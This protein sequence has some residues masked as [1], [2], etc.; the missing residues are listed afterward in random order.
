MI[1]RQNVGKH[2]H[3]DFPGYPNSR[4]SVQVNFF[5]LK[6]EL[7]HK[8]HYYFTA[9]IQYNFGTTHTV[10]IKIVINVITDL[11]MDIVY[12][13]CDIPYTYGHF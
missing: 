5:L 1:I 3:V 12:P 9:T 6:L 7:V 13:R 10:H 4:D 11:H 8:Y 2:A